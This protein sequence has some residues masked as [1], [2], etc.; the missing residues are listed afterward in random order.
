M[1]KTNMQDKVSIIIPVYNVEKYIKHCTESLIN[2]DYTNIEIIL[3][4]D[5]SPDGSGK[6]IDDIEKIDPRVKVIHKENG[7]V[8][9]AR[10]AGIHAST[11]KWI[12]FVDGDDWVESD[13]V[14]YFVDLVKNNH[15][16]IGMNTRNFSIENKYAVIA[17]DYVIPAEKTIEWIYSDK[18]FVA[19]WNKIYDADL[20]K[21]V[22]FS[23]D[24]WYGE[25]ML[26]N[27]D[28]LQWVNNVVIGEKMVY[29][30]TFNPN[31]AM[32]NFN[33]SSNYCGIASLWLQKSH[34]KKW[35]KSIENEWRYHLYRFNVSIIDGLERSG[36]IQRYKDAY[37]L[38]VKNLR[39][40]IAIPLIMEHKP[41]KIV[42]WICYFLFPRAM[43]KRRARK[44][45]RNIA[46]LETW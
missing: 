40:N 24:I 9:T 38:C 34:W 25:G 33:L 41:K 11:G 20:C 15:C 16:Q 7:G 35:N 28:C 1:N 19:V 22:L 18:L 6:V 32:R 5:G 10:N 31:S 43:A 29:H 36:Q 44:F 42:S 39:H 30:Q 12:M 14:S 26:F 3:V 13:Y 8:S 45:N 4:D 2:Q 27:I 17:H 46:L 37:K 21:R 23:S